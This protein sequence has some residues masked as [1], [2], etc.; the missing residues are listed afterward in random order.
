MKR[1]DIIIVI[2]VAVL[3]GAALLTSQSNTSS[4]TFNKAIENPGVEYVISGKLFTELPVEYDPET[5]PGLT[6]FYMEDKEG[7]IKQVFLHKAMPQGF[8]QSESINLRETSFHQN[9]GTIHAK[10]IQL[11]CPSKYNEQNHIVSE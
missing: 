7:V 2:V 5:N 11:K 9:D 6:T 10:E 8:M 1:S 3:I 4:V